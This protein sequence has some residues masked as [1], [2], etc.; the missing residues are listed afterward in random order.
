MLCEL[1][2]GVAVEPGI[3]IA[4][5]YALDPAQSSAECDQFFCSNN[6]EADAALCVVVACGAGVN[7]EQ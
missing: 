5:Q 4:K 7:G 2:S 3:D 6:R 1:T